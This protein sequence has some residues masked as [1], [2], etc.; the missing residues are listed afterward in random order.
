MPK[1][2]HAIAGAVHTKALETTKNNSYVP[3]YQVELYFL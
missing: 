2:H 3:Y 1:L